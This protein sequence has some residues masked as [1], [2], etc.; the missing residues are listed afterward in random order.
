[1]Q[2]KIW[3]VMIM[4]RTIKYKK[5][6]MAAMVDM[7]K[8][9]EMRLEIIMVIA[10]NSQHTLKEGM[11]EMLEIYIV[12]IMVLQGWAQLIKEQM[13]STCTLMDTAMEI[14]LVLMIQPG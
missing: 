5:K 11:E 12:T 6:L 9:R 4:E 1:M 10:M 2:V 14:T 8:N 13:V 7:R 3:K